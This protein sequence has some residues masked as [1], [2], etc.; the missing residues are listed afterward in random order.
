MTQIVEKISTDIPGFD[1]ISMGGL[2]RGRTTLIA[3][4]S[5]SPF[6]NINGILSGNAIHSLP[7]EIDR[8]DNLF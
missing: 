7:K 2:P 8:L 3:G 6:S 1:A 4:T 5:G